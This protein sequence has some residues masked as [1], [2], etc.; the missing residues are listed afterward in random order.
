MNRLPPIS[1]NYVGKSMNPTLSEP[2]LL[3]ILPY[4]QRA[5]RVGDIVLIAA[6]A[7]KDQIVHRVVFIDAEG[8]LTQGDNCPQR[9]EDVRQPENIL[10]R[11]ISAT[12]GKRRRS[13]Y[14]GTRGRL[15]RYLAQIIRRVLNRSAPLLQKTYKTLEGSCY[16][17]LPTRLRPR[18]VSFATAESPFYKLVI[19]KRVVGQCEPSGVCWHIRR[20]FRL[21]VDEARLPELLAVSQAEHSTSNPKPHDSTDHA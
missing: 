1:A 5:V 13:I 12:R 2:A 21:F 11:V 6:H 9:D 17:L 16:P 19:G 4:D 20:P 7:G 14:G 10:G 18:V 15:I 8:I 3:E